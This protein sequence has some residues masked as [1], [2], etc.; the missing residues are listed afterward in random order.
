MGR[1][2]SFWE[3]GRLRTHKQASEIT[4]NH[5]LMLDL[6]QWNFSWEIEAIAVLA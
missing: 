6:N 5:P 2:F 4:Q 3:N 1:L